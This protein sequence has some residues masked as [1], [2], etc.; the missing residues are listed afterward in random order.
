MRCCLRKVRRVSILLDLS[1]FAGILETR[2]HS[3]YI[4]AFTSHVDR[5]RPN[6]P[7]SGTNFPFCWWTASDGINRDAL[8]AFFGDAVSD[9]PSCAAC[10]IGMLSEATSWLFVCEVGQQ[11]KGLENRAKRRASSIARASK[12]NSYRWGGDLP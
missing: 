1:G 8:R 9:S 6:T 3:G 5:D 2:Q 7:F 10:R 4:N 12:L 11:L